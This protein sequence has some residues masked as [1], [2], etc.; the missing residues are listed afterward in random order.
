MSTLAEQMSDIMPRL[1]ATMDAWVAAGWP[2]DGPIWE[3]REAVFLEL[4]AWNERAEA[5]SY[6]A[7]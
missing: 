2:Y 5:A 6:P 7:E 4:R 1:T 3:A